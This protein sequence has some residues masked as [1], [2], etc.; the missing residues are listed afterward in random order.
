[1]ARTLRDRLRRRRDEAGY[2]AILVAMLIATVLFPIAALSVDVGR[3]YVEGERVQA[4]ADAAAMAGVTFL[5]ADF[6]SA[7]AEAVK[8]A[9]RNG[10][11]NSGTTTVTVAQGLKPTQLQV[12]ITSRIHNTIAASFGN[13][14][15]TVTRLAVADY[16]GPAPM[17][18]P[19][20]TFGNEP[21]GTTTYGPAPSQL[22]VPSGATC[23]STPQF[24]GSVYGPDIYKVD[25]DQVMVR[26]CSSSES[27]CSSGK[28]NDFR[29]C[30][31]Y[32]SRCV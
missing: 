20:N 31:L 8:V 6:S 21:L 1:M 16:N 5:P 15:T 23:S 22:V 27:N 11:P 12:T 24:W 3:M 7:Q 10:F 32:T 2:A 13:D 25:G 29:P 9:A 28:N 19:C 18:S 14:Y 17:G 4:A 26:W 30:L